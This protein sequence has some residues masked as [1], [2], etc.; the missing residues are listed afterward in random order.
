MLRENGV[1]VLNNIDLTY[2]T[3]ETSTTKTVLDHVCSN[4]KNNTF[5]MAIIESL[6]SDHKQIY[7]EMEKYKPVI[8]KKVK[9]QAVVYERLYQ[10]LEERKP[11]Q[12]GSE[13]EK[14]EK[15]IKEAISNSKI[16]KTKILNPLKADWIN[17][18]IIQAINKRNQ[19]GYELIRSSLIDKSAKEEYM[20]IFVNTSTLSL[21]ILGMF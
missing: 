12:G 15:I 11:A 19:L 14:L 21:L 8:N 10:Q 18:D 17:K 7:L 20:A 9:Y 2:C 1:S 16:T 3:R 4:V 5:N 13:Y 6:I